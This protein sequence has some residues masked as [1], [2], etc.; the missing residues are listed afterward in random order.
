MENKK[1]KYSKSEKKNSPS[2]KY[3]CE[4]KGLFDPANNNKGY[5]LF[6]MNQNLNISNT[7][8]EMATNNINV[9]NS[10]IENNYLPE[11]KFVIEA[12]N[13]NLNNINY[14][15]KKTN[16]DINNFTNDVE[17]HNHCHNFNNSSQTSKIVEPEKK[18]SSD[19]FKKN[20]KTNEFPNLIKN[21]EIKNQN[22]TKNKKYNYSKSEKK[23]RGCL[24]G[25]TNNITRDFLFGEHRNLNISNTQKEMVT[26]NLAAQNSSN[27]E[28]NHF[29]ENKFGIEVI[30]KNSNNID[31]L[32][33]LKWFDAKVDIPQNIIPTPFFSI[34]QRCKKLLIKIGIGQVPYGK[35]NAGNLMVKIPNTDIDTLAEF[36]IIQKNI[37]HLN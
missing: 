29:Y 20:A 25:I 12:I 4:F 8:K 30:N 2:Q 28:N 7:Q 14:P 35:T 21:I 26:S 9:Q 11:N 33:N 3:E 13:K 24:F 19:D 36:A 18:Q 27:L 10:S 16:F 23:N 37:N 34:H 17:H 15:R 5:C 22:S 31:L 6:G 32:E 1:F